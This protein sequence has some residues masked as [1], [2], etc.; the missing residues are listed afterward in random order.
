MFT[1]VHLEDSGEMY[2]TLGAKTWKHFFLSSL[3][4]F[5]LSGTED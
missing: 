3:L 2:I 4:P 1:V 5:P